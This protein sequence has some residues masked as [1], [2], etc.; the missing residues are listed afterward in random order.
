MGTFRYRDE[1]GGGESGAGLAERGH[2]RAGMAIFS[3]AFLRPHGELAES[4][5]K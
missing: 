1:E 5:G 2:C 4:A 3:D